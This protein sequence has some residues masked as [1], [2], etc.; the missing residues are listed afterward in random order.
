MNWLFLLES[1]ASG[2]LAGLITYFAVSESNSWDVL[3]DFRAGLITAST[4]CGLFCGFVVAIPVFVSEKKLF[5]F[6]N[7]FVFAGSLGAV[8]TTTGVIFFKLIT[9]A[10]ANFEKVS[11][12]T[13]RFFWW[14]MLACSISASF[15]IMNGGYRNFS[16]ALMG[17]MP[18]FLIAG[19]IIDQKT[20]LES[21]EIIDYFVIGGV[22]GLG[23]GIVWDMLR[24]SWLDEDAG[25]LGI[26]R[27]YLDS[28]SFWV[29]NSKFCDI[30][31]EFG[32]EV[33]FQIV[34]KDGIHFLEASEDKN[35]QL[36]DYMVRYRLLADGDI[37][38]VEKR[39]FRYHTRLARSRDVVPEVA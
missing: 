9:E 26:F 38:K 22:T 33:V 2:L 7:K 20:G 11:G 3:A 19:G 1:C 16:R 36:N 39:T 23:F 4:F 13:D 5:K 10:T 27:Y 25:K 21:T 8:I 14:I 12:K 29:G 37:I 32:G 24:E 6:L 28:D 18:A 34:E 15:G 31:I 17:I 30:T 35:V